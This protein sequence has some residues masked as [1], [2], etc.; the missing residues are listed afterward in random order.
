MSKS[1]THNLNEPVEFGRFFA[2]LAIIWLHTVG[3]S[4]VWEEST[5][6]T[7]WAVPYFVAASLWFGAI[8][9]QKESPG[10]FFLE[11]F[12]R[13]YPVFLIWNLAYLFARLAAGFLLNSEMKFQW[14]SFFLEFFVDGYAHHLWFLNFLILAQAGQALFRI[15]KLSSTF[16]AG[17]G[18][19]AMILYWFVEDSSFQRAFFSNYLLE[20][21]WWSLPAV[22]FFQIFKY[23]HTKIGGFGISNFRI[24][25]IYLVSGFIILF[26]SCGG[27][28]NSILE[29]LCGVLFFFTCLSFGSMRQALFSQATLRVFQM[30]AGI[31][32]I[33]VLFI[34]SLQDLLNH[35]VSLGAKLEIILVFSFATGA[36]ISGAFLV[37][38][39]FPTWVL[40]GVS[41]NRRSGK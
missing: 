4:G 38:K 18:A 30:A 34:E 8:K 10:K 16:S 27:N 21:S 35:M 14:N 12:L 11:R 17:L 13:L 9:I 19:I 24:F 3:G 29:A 25:W 32:L 28:R 15:T 41:L 40:E 6:F 31:Y 7:R 39:I 36:S 23:L 2:A 26:I 1:V 37:K 22:F 20:L 5:R 33:H